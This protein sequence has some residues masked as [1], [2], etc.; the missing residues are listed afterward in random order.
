MTE[1]G[2]NQDGGRVNECNLVLRSSDDLGMIQDEGY[3]SCVLA[4]LD[5]VSDVENQNYRSVQGVVDCPAFNGRV[6]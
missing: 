2:G 5:I 4:P 6:Q 3:K 1:E